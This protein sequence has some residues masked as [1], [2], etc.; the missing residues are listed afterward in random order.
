M[1]GTLTFRSE[2]GRGTTFLI[3]LPADRPDPPSI[4]ARPALAEGVAR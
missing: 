1:G 4:V 2:P 3:R